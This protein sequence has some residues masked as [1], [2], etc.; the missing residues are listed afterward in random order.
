MILCFI[1]AIS[2]SDVNHL[3]THGFAYLMYI[4]SIYKVI[5]IFLCL[6]ALSGIQFIHFLWSKFSDM[7]HPTEDWHLTLIA[8]SYSAFFKR[9]RQKLTMFCPDWLRWFSS[10]G[11]TCSLGRETTSESTLRPHDG[12]R[13]LQPDPNPTLCY[14]QISPHSLLLLH[15][16]A[17]LQM[18]KVSRAM[19]TFMPTQ[20]W[21]VGFRFLSIKLGWWAT[22]CVNAQILTPPIPPCRVLYLILTTEEAIWFIW[23]IL[24]SCQE[25]C[26]YCLFWS[27][28][29]LFFGFIDFLT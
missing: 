15:C 4:C 21:C 1:Y 22:L 26:E 3:D 14:F 10:R 20:V 19:D 5:H 28:K 18:Q 29:T 27:V 9:Q 11:A 17:V 13:K 7:P 16:G 2:R 12:E 8:Q 23:F 25:Y 24:I 6:S